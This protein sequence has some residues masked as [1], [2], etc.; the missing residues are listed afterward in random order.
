MLSYDSIFRSV[1]GWFTDLVGNL[2]RVN[3]F[4]SSQKMMQ[5]SVTHQSDGDLPIQ[6]LEI[7]PAEVVAITNIV[8]LDGPETWF[9][10]MVEDGLRKLPDPIKLGRLPLVDCIG[11]QDQSQIARGK[12]L[13]QLLHAGIESLRPAG[14]RPR[15]APSRSWYNYV[16][17]HDAYVIGIRNREVMAR[18]YISEGTFN[19]TRRN[20][21]R[22]VAIWLIEEVMNRQNRI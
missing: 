9:V 18:L 5:E 7:K 17:L 16:V 15:N 4:E 20:A 6:A 2:N 12:Q 10:K 14:A 3:L 21:I 11:V 1:T 13:Q 22:G 19:R 8:S